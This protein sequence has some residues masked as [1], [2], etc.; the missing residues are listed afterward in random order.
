MTPSLAEIVTASGSC[1]CV[2]L[3]CLGSWS[4]ERSRR[5]WHVTNK[6]VRWSGNWVSYQRFVCTVFRLSIDG[7]WPD[8]TRFI[9]R[10]SWVGRVGCAHWTSCVRYAMSV[11]N[12]TV[13]EWMT[14][15][16]RPHRAYIL[17]Y[18][19]FI[20]NLTPYCLVHVLQKRLLAF[21]LLQRV[22][23]QRTLTFEM[24]TIFWRKFNIIKFSVAGWRLAVSRS[25]DVRQ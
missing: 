10:A 25:W 15:E 21:V 6:L 2:C 20:L 19:C 1:C 7:T 12:W 4:S 9:V 5:R 17:R 13:N 3:A 14:F 23:E 16:W 24:K 8:P 18:T 11:W 22:K